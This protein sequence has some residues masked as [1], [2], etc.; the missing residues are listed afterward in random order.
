MSNNFIEWVPFTLDIVM[1]QAVAFPIFL[2][3]GLQKHT[4]KKEQPAP[5]IHQRELCGALGKE[6]LAVTCAFPPVCVFQ[7]TR[8]FFSEE[9]KQHYLR[10]NNT[11]VFSSTWNSIM[12]TVSP[13]MPAPS[14]PLSAVLSCQEQH[15]G[16][17]G[18]GREMR[19][20]LAAGLSQSE[21]FLSTR[22]SSM[23]VCMCTYVNADLSTAHGVSLQ[24]W[25]GGY[26]ALQMK[27]QF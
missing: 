15:R 27:S 5:S 9:L 17:G 13:A 24:E 21:L 22:R 10:N 25:G 23:Y 1:V 8:E 2:L 6:A 19:I 11:D 4:H 20:C 18:G 14:C 12:I 26:Q 3:W 7:L 16:R